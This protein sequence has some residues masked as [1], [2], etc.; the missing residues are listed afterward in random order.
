MQATSTYGHT[1]REMI[2]QMLEWRWALLLGMLTLGSGCS[3]SSAACGG[4]FEQ[5]DEEC[6]P[7][8][9][10]PCGIHEVC[11][12]LESEAECICAPGYTG[13]PCAWS[14]A[15]LD[16]QFTD[17]AA[18][19][20]TNGAVVL[21]L[22][23]GPTG[24]G[25][26][27]FS[28]SVTC[29]AGGVSQVFEMPDYEDAEP[30][31]VEV[32]FRTM[33]ASAAVGYGR[34]FRRLRGTTQG[35]NTDRFCLGEAGYGGPVKFQ[36]AASE[37][38]SECF[39]A[40]EGRIEV[41]R[42]EIMVAD[43]GECPRPGE[44][45]NPQADAERSGWEF[46]VENRFEGTTEASIEEGVGEAGSSGARLHKPAASSNWAAM[47]TEI[48]VAS[49][50]TLASPALRFW[51]TGTAG[52]HYSVDLG[53]RV[54]IRSIADPLDT[55]ISD[56]T[57]QDA[58]YCLPPRMHGGVFTLGVAL[59]S[60]DPGDDELVVDSVRIESDPRCGTDQDILDPS[61]DSAPNR[62]PG[63]SITPN[64]IGAA[65]PVNAVRVIAS[66]E[67][68]RPPGSGVLELE[69]ASDDTRLFVENWVWVPQ[70][71]GNAGPQVVF[72]SQVPSDAPRPVFWSLENASDFGNTVCNPEFCSEVRL[73]EELPLGGGWR[74]NAVCLPAQWAERWLRI[75]VELRGSNSG[76]FESF[77]PPLIVLIDDFSLGTDESCPTL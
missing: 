17:E 75:R 38:K 52:R 67:R 73:Q 22:G 30:F 58:T 71:E 69:Y 8:C 2:A 27:S 7:V 29:N 33:N 65:N 6:V 1:E 56:G 60:A 59:R 41:D 35:W 3:G 51:W 50:D 68:A 70:S 11:S 62:W 19:S 9:E 57:E 74:R 54:P 43:E 18:W 13:S 26:A 39:S 31:V 37:R 72:Y 40:P 63:V 77:D 32:T 44:L 20:S 42:F 34:V 46:D 36:I 45:L 25:L 64:D 23:E 5:Q 48:S 49:A 10:A 12:V 24:A 15:P 55:L 53:T 76:P 16:G 28:S 21:P 66:P 61:F 14:G 47:F 4:G